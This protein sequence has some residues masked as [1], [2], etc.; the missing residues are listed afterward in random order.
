MPSER[1][2]SYIQQYAGTDHKRADRSK[3]AHM[4]THEIGKKINEDNIKD[5]IRSGRVY[6]NIGVTQ[7]VD[8]LR[9]EIEYR[10][11]FLDLFN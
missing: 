11:Y 4:K 1:D 2:H 7:S 3:G 5:T 9:N 10:S 6:G 8:M